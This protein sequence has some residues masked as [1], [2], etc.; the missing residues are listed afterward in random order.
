MKRRKKLILKKNKKD[1]EKSTIEDESKEKERLKDYRKNQKEMKT[2][3]KE[4]LRY[5]ENSNE[6]KYKCSVCD[7][8]VDLSR[9]LIYEQLDVKKGHFKLKLHIDNFNKKVNVKLI[10]PLRINLLI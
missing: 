5:D 10:N 6:E 1:L 8:K 4:V 2:Y 9:C 3:N 7:L